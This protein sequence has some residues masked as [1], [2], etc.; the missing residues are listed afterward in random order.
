MEKAVDFYTCFL[1]LWQD[2]DPELQHYVEEARQRLKRLLE[3]D[4]RE[5]DLVS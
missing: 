5:P 2:A 4:A 1:D 3:E